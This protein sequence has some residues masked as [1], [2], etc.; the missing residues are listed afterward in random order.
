MEPY[1]EFYAYQI[2]NAMGLNA[3]PYQLGMWKGMLSSYS[4]LFTDINT[5]YVPIGRVVKHCNIAYI[6]LFV[7]GLA[8][9]QFP[10]SIL[11]KSFQLFSSFRPYGNVFRIKRNLLYRKPMQVNQICRKKVSEPEFMRI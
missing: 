7:F 6:N 1:S 11:N 2:A 3:V 4:E 10:H 9:Q 5:S 8:F